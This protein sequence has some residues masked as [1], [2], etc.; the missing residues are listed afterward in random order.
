[1]LVI[2]DKEE[3]LDVVEDKISQSLNKIR[4]EDNFQNP[5]F[6]I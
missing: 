4:V 5:I 1:V 2:S 6:R 3:A